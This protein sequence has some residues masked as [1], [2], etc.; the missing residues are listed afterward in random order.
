MDGQGSLI[1]ILSGNYCIISLLRPFRKF[2]FPWQDLHLDSPCL[3]EIT[4]T[5]Q[6]AVFSLRPQL[7]H[8]LWVLGME[9]T[10]CVRVII[11]QSP[12]APPPLRTLLASRLPCY[13]DNP[14]MSIL[15]WELTTSWL[16]MGC[17]QKWADIFLHCEAQTAWKN[18]TKAIL[19]DETLPMG[20]KFKDCSSRPICCLTLMQYF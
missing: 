17:R 12:P 3:W 19:S 8:Q 7:T 15:A 20:Q 13:H 9:G 5:N 18:A 10:K 2:S 6:T 14:P 1:C 4:D 16:L 11:A